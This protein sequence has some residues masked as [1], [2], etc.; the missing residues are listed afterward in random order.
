[1]SPRNIL[2]ITNR[3]GLR[4]CFLPLGA[5]WTAMHVPDRRGDQA[6]VLLGFA[7]PEA[8]QQAEEAYH[9]AVVGR[10]CG[11]IPRGIIQDR[12]G[13]I[14]LS[15]NEGGEHHLHGGKHGF[16]LKE[17]KLRPEYTAENRL[18]FLLLAANDEDGYPGTVDV[19][20]TYTLTND[21]QL[22]F[23]A[24]AKA[25]EKTPINI[26]N[27]AFFNLSGRASDLGSHRLV[28]NGD[29]L[30][31]DKEFLLTGEVLTYQQPHAVPLIGAV[32]SA[33]RL[34]KAGSKAG[35]AL[36]LTHPESGRCLRVYTNQPA[37]QLYNGFFMTGRDVGKHGEPYRPNT[38][39]A[40][41]PQHLHYG[42]YQLLHPEETY[43]HRTV[44]E[45]GFV[46]S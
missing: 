30:V 42:A 24:T 8:Y 7:T 20:V 37:V 6:D 4:A 10:Y 32:S 13:Q 25:T 36:T 15:R 31:Q 27:H 3:N 28:V 39:L 41:E 17:W 38:G 33:F 45:F 9:G 43:R 34:K 11:R 18:G 29:G 19:L 23:E 22:V 44:Y 14:E 46:A 40:I 26:T 1:M 12:D 35:A 21:N 5:R 16:H 2:E